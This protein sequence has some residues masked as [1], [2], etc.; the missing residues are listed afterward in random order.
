MKILLLED[1]AADADL[2][3]RHLE[4]TIENCTVKIVSSLKD[5]R[6]LLKQDHNFQIALLDINL[7]DGSGLE[8]LFEIKNK[9]WPIINIVFTGSGD[10]ELAVIALKSGA[11]DFVMK[12]FDFLSNLSKSIQFQTINRVKTKKQASI[13]INVLYIEHLIADVDLT[14]RHF[15]KYAPNFQF[16]HMADVT[17]FLDLLNKDITAI[18]PYQLL[19]IDYKLPKI[20]GLVLTKI[21]RQKL[22]L[23]IPI[24]IVTGHGNEEIAI[25]ALKLGANDYLVKRDDYI[26]KMPS[27]LQN[28]Y[29]Y[30]LLKK[31]QK[32]LERS[33]QEY[34][35]FFEDDVTGDFISTVDGY[36]ENCNP[37]Y[38]KILG[39]QSIED[40]RKEGVTSVYES[41]EDR[42]EIL[43]K[44]QERGRL[45]EYE[46]NLI[47]SDGKKIHVIANIIGIFDREKK[48]KAI[49]GYIIDNTERK[50]AVEELRKLSRAVEQSPASILITDLNG[51]IEYVN[52]KFCAISGY[53]FEEL[54]GKKPNILKTWNTSAEEYYKLWETILSGNDWS[55]EFLN[56]RK[57]ESTYWEQAII[58]G[59]KDVEGNVTHFLAVKEDIT[60]RKKFESELIAAKEKAEESDRLKSAFLANMSHEIRTPM[61]GILGFS[62]LLKTPQLSPEKQQKYIEIIEKS[63]KRMLSTINDIMDISK[64]EAGL[65]TVSLSKFNIREKSTDIFNFFKLEAKNK[66]LG[67]SMKNNLKPE[68]EIIITDREKL[69]SIM[70]NLVKNAIKF[71]NTGSIEFG[72][73]VKD[74]KLEFCI[75]DTGIGIP[76]DRQPFIFD[77]FIQAD[78]E[79]KLVHQGSGLGLAISK[80]YV[81][82]LGGTISVIS[83]EGKGSEFYFSIPYKKH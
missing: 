30:W 67:L 57:D 40:L 4:Q 64:I 77:R 13:K 29:Q 19:L 71:T 66:G 44:V 8:L 14:I 48:L 17:V 76:K 55:G 69:Y 56:K 60:Q 82:M 12:N 51:I 68:D 49:K 63:G 24:V 1:Y 52:P 31:Q 42:N 39:Y 7:T 78:I 53:S 34:K 27:V 83:E 74:K 11:D 18:E 70:T 59:I 21:I 20:D 62:E 3:K 28:A 16:E 79:D 35:L 23:D 15:K 45:V 43:K 38:L 72:F 47:R 50:I 75:K 9:N 58:T 22:K 5:A 2:I 37:A 46:F 36:I 65:M 73:T 25:Q 54:I 80:S 32:E 33:Y 6:K 81:E 41:T 26:N 10:E 61:S